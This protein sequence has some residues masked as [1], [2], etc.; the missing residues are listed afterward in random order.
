MAFVPQARPVSGERL[1]EMLRRKLA[2][3]KVPV[4]FLSWPEAGPA[5]EKSNRPLCAAQLV[6]QGANRPR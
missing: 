3:Y 5:G 6:K 4:E 2:A 1:H